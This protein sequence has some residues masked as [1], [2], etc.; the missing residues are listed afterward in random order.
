MLRLSYSKLKEYKQCPLKY[1]FHYVRLMKTKMTIHLLLGQ[2]F[3]ETVESLYGKRIELTTAQD[4]FR[5]N[6]KNIRNTAY[7]KENLDPLSTEE[8]TSFGSKGLVML[9]NFMQTP[10][11]KIPLVA[12]VMYTIPLLNNAVEFLGKV[13]RFD[14][15]DTMHVLTDYKTGKYDPRY[16]DLFQLKVYL[17]LLK[18]K[19]FT[20]DKAELYFPFENEKLSIDSSSTLVE[21]AQKTVEA[22]CQEVIDATA[23]DNFPK[24]ASILCRYCDFEKICS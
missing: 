3:H 12:E 6:W 19:G 9:Q 14:V 5:E 2:A 11:M 23:A 1:C 16:A 17:W 20:A 22:Q 18:E 21:E 10:Y 24:K 7:E 4:M 8:E 15:Y 13:D